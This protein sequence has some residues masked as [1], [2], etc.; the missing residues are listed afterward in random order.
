MTTP[1]LPG[2]L[3]ALCLFAACSNNYTRLDDAGDTAPPL[4]GNGAPSGLLPAGT[5]SV[6]MSV[7]TDKAATCR[8]DMTSD[9]DFPSMSSGFATTG[10]TAHSTPLTGLADNTG[11]TL[12]PPTATPSRMYSGSVSHRVSPE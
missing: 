6:T 1:R 7:T 2:G 10:G 8:Y 5:T 12:Q 4:I 9:L 11:T 3:T